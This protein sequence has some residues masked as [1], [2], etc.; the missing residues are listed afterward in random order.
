MGGLK[1]EAMAGQGYP[2]SEIRQKNGWLAAVGLVRLED[3]H[4]VITKI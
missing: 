1:P 3:K 2:T 4:K